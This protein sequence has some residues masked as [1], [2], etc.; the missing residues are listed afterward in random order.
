[1]PVLSTNTYSRPAPDYN[2][3]D[4]FETFFQNNAW[5]WSACDDN[6]DHKGFREGPF[7]TEAEAYAHA[8]A[9]G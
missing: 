9:N 5:W 8:L 7:D 6:G 3:W 2:G 1:M 4:A